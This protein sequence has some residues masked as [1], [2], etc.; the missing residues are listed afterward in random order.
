MGMYTE[1]HFNAELKKSTPKDIITSLRYMCG[2][3][4]ADSELDL[5]HDLFKTKSWRWMLRCES[6]YFPFKASSSIY[7]D[8][9][10]DRY[11]LEVKSQ[12][13]NYDGEIQLFI[14]WIMPYVQANGDDLLGFYRHEEFREPILI[15]PPSSQYDPDD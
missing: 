7:M 10:E 4:I 5:R 12:V 13:K 8:D 15:Y 14:D 2:E 3:S 9:F 6:A 1:F 11:T